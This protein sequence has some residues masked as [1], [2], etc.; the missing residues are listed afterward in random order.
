MNGVLL[1]CGQV[2]DFQQR[3]R[4]I[5]TYSL[6]MQARWSLWGMYGEERGGG[7]ETS[8]LIP[9]SISIYVHT[10]KTKPDT[11]GVRVM[12]CLFSHRL[13]SDSQGRIRNAR[14]DD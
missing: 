2:S 1:H 10:A 11:R 3:T 4:F 9:P 5:E 6:A 14:N 7:N 13:Y 8:C 12:R